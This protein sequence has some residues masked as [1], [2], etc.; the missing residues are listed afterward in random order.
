MTLRVV[1]W[2]VWTCMA[3]ILITNGLAAQTDTHS[4]RATRLNIESYPVTPDLAGGHARIRIEG[5]SADFELRIRLEGRQLRELTLNRETIIPYLV[6]Q[7]NTTAMI[8]LP[9]QEPGM[10]TADVISGSASP[11]VVSIRYPRGIG[12]QQIIGN[13]DLRYL[14]SD[15]HDTRLHT[16]G[17]SVARLDAV[18]AYGT[19]IPCTAL[20]VAPQLWLT[21]AHC[22]RPLGQPAHNLALTLDAYAPGKGP[23]GIDPMLRPARVV[24]DGF[25]EAERLDVAMIRTVDVPEGPTISL[26]GAPEAQEGQLLGVVMYWSGHEN[27]PPGK[28]Y[29]GDARCRVGQRGPDG[30]GA[31]RICFGTA[32]F[33]HECD[34]EGGSS[35]APILDKKSLR[36]VGLNVG[37]GD[38]NKFTCGVTATAVASLICRAAPDAGAEAGLCP[39]RSQ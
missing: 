34:T 26:Q 7:T 5:L 23:T 30:P 32:L 19:R 39:P 2:P 33:P 24:V 15:V 18:T 28:A 35:G 14:N 10:L 29:S 3:V 17:M 36:V 11:I 13:L 31:S 25:A 12:P 20:R 21:A 37:G 22:L 1:H 38:L 8:D 4:V 9:V 16:I 27:K 6:Q